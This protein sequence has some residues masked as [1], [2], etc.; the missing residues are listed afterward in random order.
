MIERAITYYCRF[1]GKLSWLG[2]SIRRASVVRR[3]KTRR[4]A[5]AGTCPGS[6]CGQPVVTVWS[7]MAPWSPL[8]LPTH[9]TDVLPARHVP[10]YAINLALI[11]I[12]IA[13]DLFRSESRNKPFIDHRKQSDNTFY[14]EFFNNVCCIQIWPSL[15]IQYITVEY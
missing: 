1:T 7:N 12:F 4:P 14:K 6:A 15:V 3:V 5:G 2:S 13:R 8:L 10:N 9:L 11:N